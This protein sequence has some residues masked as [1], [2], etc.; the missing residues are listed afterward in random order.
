LTGQS[1]KSIG[2]AETRHQPVEVPCIVEEELAATGKADR[3]QLDLADIAFG[4]GTTRSFVEDAS[5]KSG[6]LSV[7][8][9]VNTASITLLGQHMAANFNLASDGHGGTLV[10]DPTMTDPNASLLAA[11]QHA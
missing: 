8:D 10:T 3:A 4:S 9:A 5:G 1:D 11:S 6:M 7:T 2:S